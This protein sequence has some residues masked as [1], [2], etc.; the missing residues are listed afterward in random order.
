MTTAVVDA[1]ALGIR[2]VVVTGEADFWARE[3]VAGVVVGAFLAG[4]IS[5]GVGLA[6]EVVDTVFTGEPG[7]GEVLAVAGANVEVVGF[8][9]A[10][11]ALPTGD[12]V[13]EETPPAA[14][15]E[16]AAFG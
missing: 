9:S 3:L 16:A 8:L 1:L 14:G 10:G 12:V 6:G 15:G 2:D 5:F 11:E 13:T 7:T 4:E